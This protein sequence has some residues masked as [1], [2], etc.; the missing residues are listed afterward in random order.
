MSK[1]R[2]VA[3]DPAEMEEKEEETLGAANNMV[4]LVLT[5]MSG[6]AIGRFAPNAEVSQA[7]QTKTD[8]I[9]SRKIDRWGVDR[10]SGS[11]RELILLPPWRD[12]HPPNRR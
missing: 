7:F 12:R 6:G 10:S 8:Q 4:T 3:K 11:V 9:K 2:S 5:D 1:G